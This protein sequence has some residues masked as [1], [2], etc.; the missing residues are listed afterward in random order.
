MKGSEYINTCFITDVSDNIM[1]QAIVV[2]YHQ[3]D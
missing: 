3:K 2:D 1:T